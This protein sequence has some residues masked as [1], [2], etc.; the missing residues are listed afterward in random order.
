VTYQ[1]AESC[2][3]DRGNVAQRQLLR[4]LRSDDGHC[5]LPLRVG[6]THSARPSAMAAI[7]AKPTAGGD[8]DSGHIGRR[9]LDFSDVAGLL[10]GSVAI[11]AR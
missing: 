4:P 10:G 8:V 6:L 11:G 7:C 1:G 9:D 2:G 5:E 3:P